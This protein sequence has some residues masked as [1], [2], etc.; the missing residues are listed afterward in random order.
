MKFD[1]EVILV[2]FIC[3]DE[4]NCMVFGLYLLLI[5]FYFGEFEKLLLV[6]EILFLNRVKMMICLIF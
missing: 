4:Y 2:Y 5:Y 3:S 1:L 6:L